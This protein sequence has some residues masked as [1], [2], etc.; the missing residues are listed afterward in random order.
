MTHVMPLHDLRLVV[1]RRKVSLF[2]FLTGLGD[3]RRLLPV[4]AS[5]GDVGH[6]PH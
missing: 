4:L 5:R 2:A 6:G 3:C 1:L